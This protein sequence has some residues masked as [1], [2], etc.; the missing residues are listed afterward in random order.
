[1]HFSKNPGRLSPEGPEI[2]AFSSHCSTKFQP[3]LDGFISNFSEDSENIKA[4]RVDTRTVVFNLTSN[5]TEK[6]FLGH[7]VV[8]HRET[9]FGTPGSYSVY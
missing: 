7:L 1:M 5:Q 6:R 4:D 8:T 3:I 2:L 9:F